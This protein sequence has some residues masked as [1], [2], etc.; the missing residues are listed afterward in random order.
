MNSSSPKMLNIETSKT[1]TNYV[2]V[3]NPVVSNAYQLTPKG[4]K[5]I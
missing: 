3:N 5:Q 4:R 1:F 2:T